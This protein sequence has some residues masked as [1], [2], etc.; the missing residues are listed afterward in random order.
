MK[1]IIIA[2]GI[3]K[4]MRPLTNN[5]PKC[6]LDFNGKKLL[7]IHLEILRSCGISDISVIKG[8]LE[9]TIKFPGIKYYKNNRYQH[10]NILNS[11]F[12]A[13]S[14][15]DDDVIITYSDIYYQKTVLDKL[16]IS[17]YDI[18][19]AVD[20]TWHISYKNRD[21]HPI[22]E[23]ESVRISSEGKVIEIGKGIKEKNRAEGEFMGIVKLSK[24]GCVIFKETFH[25]VKEAFWKKPFHE[26]TIFEKAFLTD[27]LQELVDRKIDVHCITNEGGWKEIDTIQDYENAKISMPIS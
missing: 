12:Y 11:L 16:I 24:K 20:T 3:G 6:L 4:R 26:A 5:L 10:N 8:Y 22:E 14:E 27:M 19:I 9:E 18:S 17:P 7:E 25:D 1:A 2:A 15:M 23:A 21:S 13:E